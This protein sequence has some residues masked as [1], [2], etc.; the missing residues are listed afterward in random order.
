MLTTILAGKH[1]NWGIVV[2][3]HSRT[4]A[5]IRRVPFGDRSQ[6]E[7]A[8][9]TPGDAAFPRARFELVEKARHLPQLEQPQAT[10]ALIDG[11]ISDLYAIPDSPERRCAHLGNS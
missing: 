7:L 8:A 5:S 10:F 6:L 1:E 4:A 3:E 11:F 9:N 2:G